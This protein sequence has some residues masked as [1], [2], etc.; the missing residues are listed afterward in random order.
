MQPVSAAASRAA[1][2]ILDMFEKCWWKVLVVWVKR[3]AIL[4]LSVPDGLRKSV[5]QQGIGRL[6]QW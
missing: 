1:P 4:F 2:T 5:G 6:A 3:G